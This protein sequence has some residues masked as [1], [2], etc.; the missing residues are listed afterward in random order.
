MILARIPLGWPISRAVDPD[1]A[2]FICANTLKDKC[3]K[4][5]R[6]KGQLKRWRE[7]SSKLLSPIKNSNDLSH[8]SGTAREPYNINLDPSRIAEVLKA[9]KCRKSNKA[10]EEDRIPSGIYKASPNYCAA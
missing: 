1:H 9:L 5:I 4:I 2:F 6:T 3:G 10:R 7:H 8:F